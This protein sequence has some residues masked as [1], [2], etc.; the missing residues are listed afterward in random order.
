MQYDQ[1]ITGTALIAGLSANSSISD[2]TRLAIEGILGLT[3]NDT[4]VA[5]SWDGS[6][7][8]APPG[9]IQVV[10][11]DIAGQAGEQVSL[12]IPPEVLASAQAYI[13]ATN[14]DITVSF[15]TVERV[16][17]MG[18]GSDT[19]TVNG[20]K[21]TTLDGG[22]G[23]DTLV[24]SGGNDSITGGAGDDSI[25]SGAGNDTII[26]G[27]GSDTVD[28]GTGYDVV[29][30][31]GDYADFVFAIDDNGDLTIVNATDSNSAVTL[32]NVEFVQLGDQSVAI[33]DNVND[34]TTV[35]LYQ[36]LLG[37]SSDAGGAEFWLNG[38]NPEG[39]A[40]QD[41]ANAFFYSD[42]FVAKNGALADITDDQ[43]VELLYNNALGRSATA[44]A[45][46]WFDQLEG[47]ADRASV[48]VSIIGSD[49]AS[50]HITSVYLI[51]G[52]V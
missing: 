9:D 5:A 25:S 12:T 20:D 10:L 52:Q 34:A 24:T 47:G 50:G 4:V 38:L 6:D 8:I 15:N 51:D 41:V 43:F 2:A 17:A 33:V 44:D 26:A 1:P 3:G 27:E 13:F 23:N 31:N 39:Q 36:G 7:F 11:A 42:E 32:K 40:A 18:N 35:G 49:E 29:E 19:V 14:T 48:A 21:N 46:Y 16:I 45:Q 22:D 37:R 28:G 30:L